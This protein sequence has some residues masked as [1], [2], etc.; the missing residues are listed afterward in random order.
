MKSPPLARSYLQLILAGRG[1]A[2]LLH[3]GVT[4]NI[5]TLQSSLHAEEQQD[6][7]TRTPRSL[8]AFFLTLLFFLSYWF[9]FG[10]FCLSFDFHFIGSCSSF[11]EREREE[12]KRDRQRELEVGWIGR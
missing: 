1:K 12:K 8:C 5:K 6:S 4:G 7:T 3:W 9:C 10:L 2:R 11:A